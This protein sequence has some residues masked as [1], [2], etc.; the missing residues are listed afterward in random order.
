MN[1]RYL[2]YSEIDRTKWDN[3]I[4]NAKNR[5]LYAHSFYL[6]EMA[7]NWDGIVLN[8]YEAV[9]PLS[10]K[11]KW[12][13]KYLYQ[14]AFTQQEGIYSAQQISREIQDAFVALVCKNFRFAEITLNYENNFPA[15]NNGIEI[16]QRNNYTLNLNRPYEALYDNYDAA[17]TKSLRRI[18]KFDLMY[19]SSINYQNTINLY[20]YLYGSRLPFFSNNSYKKFERVC[21]K[22]FRENGVVVRH[23][24][25]PNN[26]LL[27]SVVLLRDENRL[28]NMISCITT[29]GKTLEANYFLYD[30]IIQEFSNQPIIFDFEGSDIEGIANFYKKFNPQNQPYPFLRYNNLPA[31]IKKIKQ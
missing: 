13:I 29:K 7:A 31:L 26:D 25:T 17:F 14:P 16:T 15:S 19:A 9:M 5:L 4:R 12:G 30:Q 6:D 24:R 10:W 28:Y 23:A 20:K 1:I 27:A 11:R 2:P 18:R 22:L 8:D 3:C 21:D